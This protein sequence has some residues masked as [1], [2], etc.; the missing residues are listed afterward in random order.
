M[1]SQRQD[2][3]AGSFRKPMSEAG[4][5]RGLGDPAEDWTDSGWRK[6]ENRRLGL[7]A[8]KALK[9][10]RKVRRETRVRPQGGREASRHADFRRF[11]GTFGSYVAFSQQEIQSPA[12]P[13][14]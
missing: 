11:P 10:G 12:C 8:A 9:A 7:W 1:G 5:D 6:R 3:A 2:R 4:S 13:L 14:L